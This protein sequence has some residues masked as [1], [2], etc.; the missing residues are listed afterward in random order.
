MV[1]GLQVEYE[2]W[3]LDLIPSIEIILS[4]SDS[5]QMRLY[6]IF[7]RLKSVPLLGMKTYFGCQVLNSIRMRKFWSKLAQWNE[8]HYLYIEVHFCLCKNIYSVAELLELWYF[9]S[10]GRWFKSMGYSLLL[11]RVLLVQFVVP[12]GSHVK[13][14]ANVDFFGGQH[15]EFGWFGQANVK[16]A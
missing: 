5:N 10:W 3:L 6:Y 13:M 7:Y 9:C 8:P 12:V 1:G 14:T 16:N 15:L 11:L 2:R 4:S